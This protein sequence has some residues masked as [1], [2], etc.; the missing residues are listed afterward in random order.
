MF[1]C[2]T[3]QSDVTPDN[4]HEAHV[5]QRVYVLC[6][7]CYEKYLKYCENFFKTEA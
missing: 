6:E 2:S 5:C 4:Y 7:E 1:T 3:C